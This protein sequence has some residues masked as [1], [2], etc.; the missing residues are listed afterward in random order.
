MQCSLARV[1]QALQWQSPTTRTDSR[2]CTHV[3]DEFVEPRMSIRFGTHLVCDNCGALGRAYLQT[4][5][6]W[7]AVWVRCALAH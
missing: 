4:A 1:A 3:D 7:Q 5:E 6:P 2:F